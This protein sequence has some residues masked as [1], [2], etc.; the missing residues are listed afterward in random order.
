MISVGKLPRWFWYS[1]PLSLL[2]V[3]AWQLV[4]L[5]RDG[6][7]PGMRLGQTQGVLRELA[8]GQCTRTKAGPAYEPRLRYDYMVDQLPYSGNQYQPL[9][10]CTDYAEVAL[11]LKDLAVGAPVTVYYSPARPAFAMLDKRFS[12]ASRILLY[13]AVLQFFVFLTWYRYLRERDD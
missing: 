6:Y 4:P 13:A 8:I 2:M 7:R 3:A 10:R 12:V 9:A 11:A 1:I 5:W